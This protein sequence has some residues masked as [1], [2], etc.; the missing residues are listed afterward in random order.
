[1]KK[2]GLCFLGLIFALWAFPQE[3]ANS[4]LPLHPRPGRVLKVME[5]LRIPIEGEGYFYEGARAIEI[6]KDGNLYINDS[7]TSARKSHLLKFSPEG[8]FLKD[9]YRQ[10]E[11]PG[12][13]Q[14]SYD[15]T[16][17][18][19]EVVLYDFMKRKIVVEDLSGNYKIQFNRDA[20]PFDTLYGSYG[21]WLVFGR[22]V[23][24]L[25]RNTSRLYDIKNAIVFLSKDGKK[26][27]ELCAL[28]NQ[29]FYISLSQGGG[30]MNWDPFEAAVGEARMFINSTQEYRV[31]VL[32]LK[33]GKTEGVWTRDYPRVEHAP[34]D[35]ERKF[36]SQFNAPKRR[37]ENDISGLLVGGGFLWVRTSMESKDK[38]IL[39]DLFDPEGRFADSFFIDI[40]GRVLRIAEGFLY[41]SL[42]E[43]DSDPNAIPA[44]VKYR[45]GEPIGAK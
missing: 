38:G 9:L 7:W 29:M 5:V 18:G 4:A 21:E 10:G 19:S 1:M 44:L 17:N 36:V 41:A 25:E 13:I 22:K 8:R 43:S 15:F 45:I 26:E 6:D 28:N 14:S 37:Y 24:P 31:Q 34:R 35:R 39:Y 42:Y 2:Y 11:G 12:E 32:D 40:K 23:N 27:R 33:T 3:K 20:S 16:L 30:S